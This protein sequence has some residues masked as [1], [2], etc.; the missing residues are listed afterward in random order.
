MEWEVFVFIWV[1]LKE[2]NEV[3]IK[4]FCNLNGKVVGVVGLVYLDG[5]E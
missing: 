4:V 5:I 3:M 1:L 2:C